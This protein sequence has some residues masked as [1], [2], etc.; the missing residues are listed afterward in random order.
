MSVSTDIYNYFSKITKEAARNAYEQ[1]DISEARSQSGTLS[2][3]LENISKN[4]DSYS[5][6]ELSKMIYTISR[7]QREI[8]K[9]L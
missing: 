8:F 9:L 2:L 4:I 6:D 1:W 7:A 3:Y 5:N